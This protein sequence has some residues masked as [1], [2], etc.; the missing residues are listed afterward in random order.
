MSVICESNITGEVWKTKVNILL[1]HKSKKQGVLTEGHIKRRVESSCEKKNYKLI[2]I[3]F[4]GKS[5][6]HCRVLYECPIHGVH[7][8]SYSNFVNKGSKCPAC[9]QSGYNPQKEGSFYIVKWSKEEHNFIKL[10][11]TNRDVELRVSEQKMETFYN[12]N[13]L[14]SRQ[15]SDGKIPLFIED[16]IKLSN[17]FDLK[18]V[19]KYIYSQMVLLRLLIFII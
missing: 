2:N 12:Y 7:T 17:I 8:A 13:I 1:H 14:Y 6:S 16:S 18:V 19:D 15:W 3:I 9:R 11:I 4:N 10:G 5:K